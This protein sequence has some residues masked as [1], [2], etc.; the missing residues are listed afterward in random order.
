MAP[1]D[2]L[3]QMFGLML[4]QLGFV[5]ARETAGF[6]LVFVGRHF[7]KALNDIVC[8]D[9]FACGCALQAGCL[10]FVTVSVVTP[11]VM[12]LA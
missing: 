8:C 10:S 5:R 6:G 11:L 2:V 7:A 3:A 1:G 12:L 9:L 4:F